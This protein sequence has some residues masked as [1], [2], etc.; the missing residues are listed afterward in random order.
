MKSD[1]IKKDCIRCHDVK[2][3]HLKNKQ[4]TAAARLCRRN[5]DEC[6][7]LYFPAAAACRRQQTDAAH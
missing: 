3:I 6:I 4:P 5:S 1:I 2:R 7:F